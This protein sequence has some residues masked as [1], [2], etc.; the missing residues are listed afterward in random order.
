MIAAAEVAMNEV[1]RRQPDCK[2]QQIAQLSSELQGCL[3]DG[4]TERIR[5]CARELRKLLEAVGSHARRPT[6]AAPNGRSADSLPTTMAHSTD[7]ALLLDKYAR[8]VPRAPPC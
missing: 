2:V 8:T 4:P 5:G 7:N 6:G 3:D 1:A